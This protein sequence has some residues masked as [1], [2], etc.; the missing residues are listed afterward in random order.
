MILRRILAA[1]VAAVVLA[2]VAA[3][4]AVA[5]DELPPGCTP[6]NP[7]CWP[8][9]A[10][11]PTLEKCMQTGA[12]LSASVDRLHSEVIVVTGERDQARTDL[13]ELRR[14]FDRVKGERD[15]AYGQWGWWQNRSV[16]QDITLDRKDRTIAR[17][18]AKLAAQ[19]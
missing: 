18:R 6:A 3:P 12:W 16:R 4:V 2:L 11:D 7:A 9:P 15:H 1:G 13:L 8:P 17:L 5:A 14:D 19:Q 10:E